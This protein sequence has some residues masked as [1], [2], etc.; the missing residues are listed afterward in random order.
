VTE[1]LLYV[2]GW[3]R[4]AADGGTVP[5]HDPAT[6]RT[7]GTDVWGVATVLALVVIVSIGA[8]ALDLPNVRV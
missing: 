1:S 7:T 8:A 6:G 2:G 3:L 4:A 5:L